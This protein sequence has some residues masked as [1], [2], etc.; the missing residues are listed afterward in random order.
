MFNFVYIIF[1]VLAFSLVIVCYINWYI[2]KSARAGK[3]FAVQVLRP[4]V[5]KITV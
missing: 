4:E 2:C 5:G 3:K 1:D